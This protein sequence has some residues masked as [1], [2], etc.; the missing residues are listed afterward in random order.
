M[1]LIVNHKEHGMCCT[2]RLLIESGAIKDDG[3]ESAI[4]RGSNSI[5]P[6][7]HPESRKMKV[8]IYKSLK[9]DHKE[10]I[11]KLIG[12]PY[13]YA[14][15]QP[16]RDMVEPDLKAEQFYLNYRYDGDKFLSIEI[17]NK[18]S[19]AASFLN[20]LA[21]AQGNKRQL[22]QQ[23]N[24]TIE[25]LLQTACCIINSDNI[26]LPK[27]VRALQRRLQEYKNSGY[28]CLIH[29]GYGNKNSAKIGK[30]AEGYDP[31]LAEKQKAFILK[32]ASLHNNFDA[33]QITKAINMI[34][35]KQGWLT[36]SP[37]TVYNL[38]KENTHLITP[39]SRG[40]REYNS[41]IAMQVK[42]RAPEFPLQYL[43]LDGWTVELLYQDATGF[44]HRLVAVIVLD[45]MNKYPVGYAIGDRENVEL[46]K[47]A[48]RNAAIHIEELFGAKY[49]PR[50]LQSDNYGIKALTPFYTAMAHLH[51][52]AAVGNA[53]AKI[54]EP[55]FMYLNKKYCQ[56][57]PNWSGFNITAN[58]NNQPNTEYLDKTKH[59]LPN[60]AG[61]EKQIHMMIARER[62]LKQGEYIAKWNLL[63][64][65]ERIEMKRMDAL[66]VYGQSTGFTNAIT[67]Q[68]LLPTIAGTK[69]TFDTFDPAFRA[70]ANH[71]WQVIYDEADLTSILAISE[72][73]KHRF[74]LEQK[75]ELPMAIHD[76]V[77][78]DHKYLSQVNHFKKERV[79]EIMDTYI[80]NDALVE[81]VMAS[82]PFNLDDYDE[83]AL[84]LMF[85]YGGQ[86]K[87][88]LQDAK[89]LKQVQAKQD[90]QLAIENEQAANTWQQQ[91]QSFLQSKTDINQYLD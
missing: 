28:E 87:E 78:A 54:I 16:I 86:Q 17:R 60:R 77:P 46:I 26:D 48:N 7:P 1:N 15:N 43:T 65:E 2:R 42:R 6:V 81:E 30:D 59:N 68:G 14:N 40:K 23:Y 27:E 11:L 62:L 36:I 33:M 73:E 22:R 51:T 80:K 5:I 82:T 3:I 49:Q 45:A 35:E 64:H 29:S 55:Y 66:M 70:L 89:G 10:K 74:V 88:K 9:A 76:M 47:Q 61:V 71:N 24:L 58:K 13:E 20:M 25:K 69:Y 4:R 34:F 67:G 84:K 37:T 44:H 19:D 56:P 53:K 8:F 31:E 52:P 41:S 38:I 12:D 39:G 75:R 85:T 57:Q 18:Y 72:D 21:K 32:A 90:K 91:Q 50:Q 63:P 83:A 79:E